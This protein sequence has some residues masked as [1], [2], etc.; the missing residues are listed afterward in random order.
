M[1]GSGIERDPEEASE[2]YMKAMAQNHAEA[3]EKFYSFYSKALE[4]AAKKGD[5]RAQFETG[6][7]YLTGTTGKKD[8]ETAA[9]WSMKA[10]SQGH[11]EATE[12]FYS[13]YSKELEKRA[14]SGDARAQFETGNSYYTGNVV[15]KND[16]TAAEWYMKAML[17][18]HEAATEKFYSFYSKDLE[19]RAK[20]GDARAQF[21]TGNYYF[22]GLGVKTDHETA[23]EW[24]EMAMKQG[25][26]DAKTK[27]YAFY[28]KILEKAAKNGDAE[29][30]FQVGNFYFTGATGK[31]DIE[32]AAEWYEKGMSQGHEGA[33]EK[34]YSY[35][36]KTLEKNSK[37]DIEALYRIGCFYM[38]G[39]SVEKDMKKAIKLLLKADKDGHPEAFNKFG[40]VFNKELQKM[41]KKGDVRAKLA[42][43]KC[44]LNGSG[45]TKNPKRAAEFLEEIADDFE[46][47]EEAKALLQSIENE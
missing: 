39:G 45:I 24:Y 27:F 28:S 4:K 19:K 6:N 13:T 41:A 16:N 3:T 32:T 30:Q 7:A 34:Y 42:I 36:S 22:T 26:E 29:A 31:K 37:K 38:D 11:E 2:W 10:M 44:Y 5:A 33:K 46:V 47:G 15:T 21:E 12:K 40:S 25:H 23:A 43:A 20:G 14:K 35:Y 9:E 18:G 1:S 17:Q 8:T